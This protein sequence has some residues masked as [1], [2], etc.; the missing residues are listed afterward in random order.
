MIEHGGQDPHSTGSRPNVAQPTDAH[1][2]TGSS[3]PTG[4]QPVGPPAPNPPAQTPGAPGLPPTG[5]TRVPRRGLP[6]GLQIAIGALV[7]ITAFVVVVIL[8]GGVRAQGARL[9]ITIL[10]L[11]V[12]TVTLIWDLSLSRR[13]PDYSLAVA[14][15]GDV[16]L[17]GAGIIMTWVSPPGSTQSPAAALLY[18]ILFWPLVKLPAVALRL[19]VRPARGSALLR[20][21][22]VLGAAL[23]GLLTV[24]LLVAAVL[25]VSF[26]VLASSLYWRIVL[27]VAMIAFLPYAVYVILL[28]W[29]R[30]Q[31]E[32]RSKHEPRPVQDDAGYG[33]APVAPAPGEPLPWPVLEDG[34]TPLPRGVD[35][36]P[37]F[38]VLRPATP[39][40]AGARVTKDDPEAWAAVER[41]RQ[42]AWRVG[43][44]PG[45]PRPQQR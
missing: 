38:S 4:P 15:I 19:T 22:A 35:G 14:V 10:Y 40:S 12:A 34:V 37:E 43:G 21:I 25:S 42:L 36:Q 8:A 32:D 9:F 17:L 23:I 18:L 1:Q 3:Q 27:A 26:G 29:D 6:L 24:L 44:G 41:G 16:V 30:A 20:L 28:W 13:D 39:R 11:S 31:N 45:A 33:F 2:P 7:L 5:S